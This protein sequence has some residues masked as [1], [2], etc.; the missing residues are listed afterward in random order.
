MS[1]PRLSCGRPPPSSPRLFGTIQAA[2]RR[3]RTP[4]G[5]TVME[6]SPRPLRR[7]RN[8]PPLPAWT[9]QGGDR[10]QT[11]A[12]PTGWACVI[13]SGPALA[14]WPRIRLSQHEAR[15]RTAP[16]F[17]QQRRSNACR[18]LTTCRPGTHLCPLVQR[19]APPQTHHAASAF[20]KGEH[21]QAA[22]PARYRFV[23]P[24]M[25]AIA[26]AIAFPA[27]RALQNPLAPARAGLHGRVPAP[28]SRQQGAC[29]ELCGIVR[30][31]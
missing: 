20:P 22:R 7:N 16:A 12:A 3:H 21:Q 25:Q 6:R 8:Q 31:C 29:G 11:S 13:T 18:T 9:P 5:A 24:R 26:T 28:A 23:G 15:K 4:P 17:V 10:K 14:F 1:S 30:G 2:G 19:A 27:L